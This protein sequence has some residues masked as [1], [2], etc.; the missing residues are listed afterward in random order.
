MN[1]KLNNN[2]GNGT[3]FILLKNIESIINNGGTRSI[4]S[5]IRY[6]RRLIGEDII[7]FIVLGILFSLVQKFFNPKFFVL[8]L[9]ILY[10]ISF[11]FLSCHKILIVRLQCFLFDEFKHRD[12]DRFIDDKVKKKK[13]Q[14]HMFTHTHSFVQFMA[15][16]YYYQHKFQNQSINI[17]ITDPEKNIDKLIIFIFGEKKESF[18]EEKKIY[19]TK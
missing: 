19:N 13:S 6:K 8:L 12:I 10:K 7:T 18:C 3:I 17:T 5:I 11:F 4:I 9:K 14:K 16:H 2:S 15:D 1:I